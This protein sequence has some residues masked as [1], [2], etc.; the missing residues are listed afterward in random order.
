VNTLLVRQRPAPIASRRSPAPDCFRC[1][2]RPR[3]RSRK[4]ASPS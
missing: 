3:A 2:T 4:H 1:G